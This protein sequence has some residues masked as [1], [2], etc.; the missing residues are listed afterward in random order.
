[1][2]RLLF[3]VTFVV[4]TFLMLVGCTGNKEEVSGE[5]NEANDVVVETTQQDSSPSLEGFIFPN[6]DK[7]K[8][9][10]S[11]LYSLSLEELGRGRNEIFARKGHIFK[12]DKYIQYFE[13]MEWYEPQKSISMDDLN[14]IEKYNVKL[15]QAIEEDLKPKEEIS[16]SS[17]YIEVPIN[18]SYEID[19]DGDGKKDEIKVVIDNLEEGAIIYVN[20]A[21]YQSTQVYGMSAADT[22]AVV[23]VDEEDKFKEIIVS[24]YGPSYDLSSDYLYY[25]GGN[26]I[27]M[28]T[29]GGL[30]ND[31]ITVHGDGTITSMFRFNV[32]QT[33][34]GEEEYRLT[35]NHKL[36]RVPQELY[37]T[38]YPLT[39]KI[40][41]TLL[42]GA[43][44]DSESFTVEANQPITLIGT[45][46]EEWILV[47]D[48]NGQE[49]WFKTDLSTLGVQTDLYLLEIFDGV[50]LAD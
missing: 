17:T 4:F 31:G 16:N 15:I 2:K 37:N 40:D 11:D 19:M 44:I 41:I 42:A 1:M 35:E 26:I 13:K 10:D 12:S 8:L 6:S 18:T 22:Y 38:N 28:G 3:K 47:K 39:T 30:H 33:W 14:D 20:D 34:Y 25:D 45:D 46:N 7:E 43:D 27:D 21:I 23:D 50:C 29:T 5:N 48:K 36:S 9:S 32:F 24:D 49:G